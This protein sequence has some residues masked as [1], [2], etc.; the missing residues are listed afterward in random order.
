MQK[1]LQIRKVSAGDNV[2]LARMIR[3]VFEEYNAPREGTVYTDPTTDDL[4]SLFKHP[5]AV[6]WVAVWHG[7]TVGCCGIY[8]TP[9]LDPAYAE[10]VKFYL[11]AP[12]R[13]R[14][15]GQALL[16]QSVD[17]ARN[18]SYSHLYIESMPEFSKAL[19]IYEQLGFKP[20]PGPLGN[21]GHSGCTIWMLKEL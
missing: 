14:G 1:G 9:G 6:L 8:P 20:L 18:M 12:A 21:S 15:I 11:A 4:F 3:E 17:S 2:S 7:K 10:L 5:G 19:G 13:G 16:E